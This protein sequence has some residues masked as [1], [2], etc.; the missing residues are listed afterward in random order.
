MKR[1]ITIRAIVVKDNKLLCVQQKLY[2][3][4]SASIQGI[5]CLPGGG[6]EDGES[7]IPGLEREIIEE[8]GVKPIVGHLL[9]VQQFSFKDNEFLEFF[10]NVTNSEDFENIDLAN[11]THGAEEIEKIEFIDPTKSKI[12]PDFL[13]SDDIIK[14]TT[15]INHTKIYTYLNENSV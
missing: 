11:T 3:A 9:Y 7:L 6:L 5:W 14:M 2:N 4:V 15:G 13:M 1:R 10:F 8:T 12:L